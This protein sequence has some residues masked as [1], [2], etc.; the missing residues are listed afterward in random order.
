MI[1]QAAHP[2]NAFWKHVIIFSDNYTFFDS[3][4][5][6]LHDTVS[7]SSYQIQKIQDFNIANF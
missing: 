2:K 5:V 4:P 6:F 7:F 1:I 3:S